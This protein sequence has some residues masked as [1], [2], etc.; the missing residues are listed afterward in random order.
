MLGKEILGIWRFTRWLG[1]HLSKYQIS[2]GFVEK[3]KLWGGWISW[4][5]VDG[6]VWNYEIYSH[7]TSDEKKQSRK[8]KKKKAHKNLWNF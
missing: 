8:E 1:Y 5:F 4:G 7:I 2:Y 3:K 6:K